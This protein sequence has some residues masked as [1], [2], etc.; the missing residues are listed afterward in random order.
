MLLLNYDPG[1]W[2][3]TTPLEVQSYM[4]DM[5]EYDSRKIRATESPYDVYL[6]SNEINLEILLTLYFKID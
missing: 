4:H 6:K 5:S 3:R 1:S 2:R